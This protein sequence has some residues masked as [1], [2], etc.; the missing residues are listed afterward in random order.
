MLQALGSYLS[1]GHIATHQAQSA[2]Q[3]TDPA[4][5]A[6]LYATLRTS[7]LSLVSELPGSVKIDPRVEVRL[8]DQLLDG[9][10]THGA[11]KAAGCGGSVRLE[12]PDDV[13][14]TIGSN[15]SGPGQLNCPGGVAVDG[16]GNILVADQSNHRVQVLRADGTHIRTIGSRGSGPGQFSRPSGVAMDGDG[17]VLVADSGN[18]RV[19]VLR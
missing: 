13:V 9:I 11:V 14:H 5:V 10:R 17:N 1:K 8:S 4:Q 15:G 3:A 6:Q 16:D 2:I 19:Q 12:G 7:L 18:N